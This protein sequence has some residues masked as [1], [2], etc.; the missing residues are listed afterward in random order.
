[1]DIFNDIP[2]QI[3]QKFAEY[4]QDI[5]EI[6]ELA[7]KAPSESINGFP[8]VELWE[9]AGRLAGS[10]GQ[11]IAATLVAL[12]L[13]FEL[14]SL[15]NRSDTKGWDGIYWILM[16]FLK[17]AVML[18]VCKHMTLI[19]NIIFQ[20]T[21]AIVRDMGLSAEN[22]SNN[23]AM[24]TLIDNIQDYYEG[25]KTGTQL[26]GLAQA[27]LIGFIN[28]V[29]MILASI[30][31]KLRFIE[32]YVLVAI[33]PI[34]FCTF[35]SRDYKNIAI[36]YIKRLMALGLQGAFIAIVCALYKSIVTASLGQIASSDVDI[37]MVQLLGYSLMLIIAI[38]QTG[39]WSKS[40]LQVN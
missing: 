22:I 29:C 25:Q 16:A 4:F 13:F 34:P 6:F 27:W 19:I 3:A 35:V 20:I 28:H 33:A 2:E 8:S 12:F 26:F 30:V 9:T 24:N 39:G 5:T 36:S 11:G 10:I 18:T 15:F 37:A 17:V 14:A 40:L 31:C 1:M 23:E 32:I 7:S 21:S 38:F